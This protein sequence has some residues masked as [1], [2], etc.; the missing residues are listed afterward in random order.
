MIC[1]SFYF[2]SIFFFIVL[3]FYSN[4]FIIQVSFPNVSIGNPYNFHPFRM[5]HIKSLTVSFL[6][7]TRGNPELSLIL[8]G[9]WDDFITSEIKLTPAEKKYC[10]DGAAPVTRIARAVLQVLDLFL[11]H[12]MVFVWL[13]PNILIYLWMPVSVLLYWKIWTVVYVPEQYFT[14]LDVLLLSLRLISL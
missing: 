13:I 2:K 8:E 10:S 11:P 1:V 4:N 7:S 14:C 12:I 6:N 5:W 3:S 9:F